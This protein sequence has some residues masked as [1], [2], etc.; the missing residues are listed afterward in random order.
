M[1][2]FAIECDWVEAN[3]CVMIKRLAPERQR[4]RVLNEDEIRRFCAALEDEPPVMAALF[5]LR[6]LT[7]QRGGEVHGA[8]WAEI[9][10][11]SG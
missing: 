3:P 6:L 4:D 8:T 11:G 7:A 1:F 10:L 5:K 9:D 2:N